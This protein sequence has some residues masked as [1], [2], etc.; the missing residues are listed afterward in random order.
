[1]YIVILGG[2]FLRQARVTFVLLGS[3]SGGRH[4]FHFSVGPRLGAARGN[5]I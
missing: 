1:M 4:E 2:L 3:Y 5:I